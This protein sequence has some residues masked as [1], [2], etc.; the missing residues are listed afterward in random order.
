MRQLAAW[1]LGVPAGKIPGKRKCNRFKLNGF[2]ALCGAAW[3]SDGEQQNLYH[4][5]ALSRKNNNN[6]EIDIKRDSAQKSSKQP[7]VPPQSSQVEGQSSCSAKGGSL[8]SHK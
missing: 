3:P 2:A 8:G 4:G 1:V 5:N 7:S 6:D